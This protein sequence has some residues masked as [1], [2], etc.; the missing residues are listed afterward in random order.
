MTEGLSPYRFQQFCRVQQREGLLAITEEQLEE[1]LDATYPHPYILIW[2]ECVRHAH[3]ETQVL[4]YP[5]PS[6][7]F[8]EQDADLMLALSVC[9]EYRAEQAKQQARQEAMK[10]QMSNLFQGRQ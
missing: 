4:P 1:V 5:D 8:L 6:Q 9:E 2:L 7:G 3:P 10:E